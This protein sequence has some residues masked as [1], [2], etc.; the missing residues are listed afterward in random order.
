MPAKTLPSPPKFS[1][2]VGPSLIFLGLGLGSGE[3]IVWP[4]L[5]ANHGLGIIWAAILG[6]TLQFFMNM[7]IE[8][9]ALAK[10]ESIFVG[11]WR[12]RKWL[13]VWF[14]L[15]TFIPWVWPGL[16]TSSGKIIGNALGTS[17]FLFISIFELVIIGVILSVG[18]SIYKSMESLQKVIILVSVP[19]IFGLS[20]WF[21]KP[22]NI[23]ELLNGFIGRGDGFWFIPVGIPLASFLAGLAYSGAGGNLNLAQSFYIKDKGYGMG[24]YAQALKG[25]LFSK[26]SKKEIKLEGTAFSA[27]V[28]EVKKFN[29]WWRLVNLEHALI[30]WLTGGVTIILL[31]LLAFNAAHGQSGLEEG[32]NFLFLESKLIGE[33]AFPLLGNIFLILVGVCLFVTQLLVFEA[34]SRIMSENISLLMPKV[35]PAKN[36]SYYFSFFVWLQVVGGIVILKLGFNQPLTLIFLAACLNAVAMFVHSGL[37]LWLNKTLLPKKIQPSMFRQFMMG[38]TFVFFGVF[39]IITLI[40][41]L[42]K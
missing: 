33:K 34:T 1:K 18:S 14:I 37:T 23:P 39:S 38:F 30:F 11:F 15:S 40:Q 26:K 20:L 6:L 7:E 25:L 41:Q 31:C 42:S 28:S 29:V 5:V 21:G 22:S 24:K 17:N 36:L 13:P 2:L 27:T 8:R 3:L 35:F 10:G 19:T 12:K 32:L 16:V 4:Y 9:Y